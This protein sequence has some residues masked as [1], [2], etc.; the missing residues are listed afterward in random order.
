MA[1]L[2]MLAVSVISTMKV[3]MPRPSSSV[4]PTRAKMRSTRPMRA[5][6]GGDEAAHLGQEGDQ[7][8]L[9]DVGAILPAMLGPVRMQDEAVVGLRAQVVGDELA[10]GHEGV[11]HGVAAVD[12]VRGRAR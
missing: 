10:V 4:A 2:R 11:E 3:L 5:R 7:G 1:L 8:H 12:R 9:A 6:A